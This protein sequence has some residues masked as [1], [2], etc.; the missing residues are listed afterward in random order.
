MPKPQLRSPSLAG[1]RPGATAY[2]TGDIQRSPAK[3]ILPELGF[4]VFF[5]ETM[6]ESFSGAGE[7]ETALYTLEDV[8]QH[9]TRDDCWIVVDGKVYDVTKFLLDH[10]GGD[11]VIIA[12]TGK[13][14]T[15]DFENV[16]HSNSARAMM[17]E[18]VIGRANAS[19]FPSKPSYSYSGSSTQAAPSVPDRSDLLIKVLQ[20]VVP[21]FILCFALALRYLAKEERAPKVE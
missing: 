16:G 12:S 11:E 4:F 6:G 2:P 17:K 15:D 9:S 14:A 13:D 3:H 10:P 8:L 5:G 1:D 21:F 19:T 18:Y 7:L 20:F